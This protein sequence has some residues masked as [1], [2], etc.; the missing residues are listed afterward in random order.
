MDKKSLIAKAILNQKKK[1]GVSGPD[2]AMEESKE[3]AAV[4]PQVKGESKKVAKKVVP[5]AKKNKKA[6]G[7]FFFK[8]SKRGA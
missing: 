1:Y 4:K 8:S 2:S 5:K 7:A 3:S 6:A